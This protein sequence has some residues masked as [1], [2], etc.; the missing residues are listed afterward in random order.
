MTKRIIRHILIA[1]VSIYSGNSLIA[2]TKAIELEDIWKYYRFY[3]KGVDGFSGMEDGKSYAAFG[4]QKNS[5]T[6]DRYEFKTGN[7]EETL[8]SAASFLE[9]SNGI[10]DFSFSPDEEGLLIT[11]QTEKIYRH[12]SKGMTYVYHRPNST[13]HK[14]SNEPIRNAVF[15]PIDDKIAYSFENNLYVKDLPSDKVA[16]ITSDGSWNGIINGTP[17][18]VYEEEFSFDRAFEWSPNGKHIAFIKFDE[19]EVRSFSMDLY[20]KELY[21][22]R[23]EFK[24]PKAGEDNSAVSLWVYTIEGEAKELNFS[25]PFE[26]IARIYWTSDNELVAL[27]LNRLQNEMRLV[28]FNSDFTESKSIYIEKDPA[29]IELPE[30]LHFLKDGSFLINS[31]KD[32]NNRLYHCSA[33]QCKAITPSTLELTT[34][35]GFNEKKKTYYFQATTADL[36]HQRSIYSGN[37]K[38]RI[39]KISTETGWNTATFNPQ[40]TYFILSFQNVSSPPTYDLYEVRKFKK[41]RNLE[42]NS[43]L[44]SKLKEYV[45]GTK[46]FI[47]VDVNGTQLNAWI[48]KPNDFDPNKE[49]PVLTFV[50]G[51]PG[52]QTVKDQYDAANGMWYH[53]LANKGYIIA[54]VDNRGTGA[55]GRDFKKCTYG[56]LGKLEIEDQIGFAQYVGSLSF[57]DSKRIGIWGWSYGGYMSSL[58]MTKGADVYSTGIAVAPVTNWRFYD[59]IYTERYMGLPQDNASGYDE[60]S[61]INHT[62]KMKGAYLLIHGSA[63]DNVHVQ[64]TMRMTESLIQS[65]VDFQQFIY[66]DKNHGIYGGNTRFH[67][68]NK[69]THF[70][71]ENL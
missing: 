41:I 43:A 5:P 10:D 6:I 18:W 49:Y 42:D 25:T 32:G 27:T 20:G 1:I 56:Q 62:S 4:K 17:D 30:V 44:Q 69:M 65:N 29:Y 33:D 38:A 54:S 68:F 12:S 15:S 47:K 70:L 7:L 40:L 53:M 66:P 55:R 48:I 2:Q 59:N 11:T 39:K 71:E 21:P 35:Y 34:F 22:S 58:G 45:L 60:N 23:D 37:L 9:L 3:A 63:D 51:G 28:Q 16:Q 14:L 24:Y 36:A 31:D 19:S 50:Y 52:S 8:I 67:L 61:P 26:Y 57:I 13:L 64:N 46:E